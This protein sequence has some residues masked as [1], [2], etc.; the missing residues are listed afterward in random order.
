MGG[1]ESR[2]AWEIISKIPVGTVIGWGVVVMGIIGAISTGIV[3]IY[4]VFKKYSDMKQENERQKEQLIKH[5]ELLV[6]VSKSLDEIKMTLLD[7]NNA[8]LHH[9]RYTIA[10]ACDE[11]IR[12]GEISAGKL[13]SL[14]ELY[15]EYVDVFHGNG[16]I[17]TMMN[18]VRNLP[19]VGSLDE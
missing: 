3:K 8:S 19:I 13:E 2:A 9:L 5:D 15:K 6:E 10:Q 4:K 16:Y 1:E 14:E 17:K 12:Q 7:Q 18:K 11:A